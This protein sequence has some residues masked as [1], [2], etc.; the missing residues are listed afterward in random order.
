MKYEDLKLKNFQCSHSIWG[1]NTSHQNSVEELRLSLY[2]MDL[3]SSVQIEIEGGFFKDLVE[4][5][6]LLFKAPQNGPIHIQEKAL[7]VRDDFADLLVNKKE[8]SD[9]TKNDEKKEKKSEIKNDDSQ[10]ESIEESQTNEIESPEQ[11]QALKTE[12][13]SE[14]EKEDPQQENPV[15]GEGEPNSEINKSG[16]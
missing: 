7:K 15:G 9:E 14:P 5:R 16:R 2:K 13:Q 8:V 4:Y 3:Q 12:N 11:E 6:K 10:K 1:L